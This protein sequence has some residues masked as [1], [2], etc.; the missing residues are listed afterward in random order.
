[1]VW[2]LLQSDQS[3]A[4]TT[5]DRYTYFSQAEISLWP[6][7]LNL[8]HFAQ[9]GAVNGHFAYGQLFS[10]PVSPSDYYILPS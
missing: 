6:D 7:C 2:E 10:L 3:S 9:N 4:G 8:D 5:G 1:M